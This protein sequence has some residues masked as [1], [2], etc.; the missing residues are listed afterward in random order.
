LPKRIVHH[1]RITLL[2]QATWQGNVHSALSLL[3]DLK[4]IQTSHPKLSSPKR[5]NPLRSPRL[6]SR[7]AAGNQASTFAIPRTSIAQKRHRRPKAFRLESFTGLSKD[8]R[9]RQDLIF[10]QTLSL[11]ARGCALDIH[12]VW[13]SYREGA[14]GCHAER[15]GSRHRDSLGLFHTLDAR[16]LGQFLSGQSNQTTYT[17]PAGCDR[18]GPMSGRLA[19]KR[20]IALG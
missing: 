9:D 11:W 6:E 14:H 12:H 20:A 7:G 2:R 8:N 13:G 19:S 15:G 3:G 1:A 10:H 5:R 17:A 18:N 4:K 16:V